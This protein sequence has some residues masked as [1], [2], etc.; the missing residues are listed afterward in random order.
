M[1]PLFRA[2][3]S[4]NAECG[5]SSSVAAQLAGAPDRKRRVDLQNRYTE[6]DST[7]S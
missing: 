6:V 4:R 2:G 7:I 1:E 3:S 5:G